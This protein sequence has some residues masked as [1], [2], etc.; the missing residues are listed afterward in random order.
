MEEFINNLLCEGDADFFAPSTEL[1]SSVTL[2]YQETLSFVE[3]KFPWS[4]NP[5]VHVFLARLMIAW[6]SVTYEWPG[7]AYIRSS[8]TYEWSRVSCAWSLLGIIA[9]HHLPRPFAKPVSRQ[10]YDIAWESLWCLLRSLGPINAP[11]VIEPHLINKILSSV[12][13]IFMAVSVAAMGLEDYQNKY[14]SMCIGELLTK[15]R[16]NWWISFV[17]TVAKG[18]SRADFTDTLP[19]PFLAFLREDCY[20]KHPLTIISR[21]FTTQFGFGTDLFACTRAFDLFSDSF[22]SMILPCAV[23]LPNTCL[24]T[25]VCRRLITSNEDIQ[26]NVELLKYFLGRMPKNF[27]GEMVFVGDYKRLVSGSPSYSRQNRKKRFAGMILVLLKACTDAILQHDAL[28]ITDHG[29]EPDEAKRF[30]SNQARVVI[31]VLLEAAFSDKH[32]FAT[33]TVIS[34]EGSFYSRQAGW[35]TFTPRQMLDRFFPGEFLEYVPE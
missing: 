1:G 4:I 7:D 25:E 3:R 30:F 5:E 21:T 13:A 11:R 12:N 28:G 15:D 6:P 24:L 34:T 23:Y 26:L 20:V 29:F 32:L 8:T 10:D 16:I 33:K 35:E 18:A 27:F 9:E 22:V 2:E 14:M 31:T 19:K 17:G